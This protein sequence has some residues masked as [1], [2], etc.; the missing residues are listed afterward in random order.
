MFNDAQLPPEEAYYA[1][2]RDLEDAT[3]RR[4]ELDLENKKLK[5]ELEEANLK[6]EQ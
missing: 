6:R 3:T 4:N 1:L 2:R 5:R